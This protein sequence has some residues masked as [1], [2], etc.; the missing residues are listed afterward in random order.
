MKRFILTSVAAV[1]FAGLGVA[2]NADA[3]PYHGRSIHGSPHVHVTSRALVVHGH[4]VNVRVYAR[5]YNSWAYRCWFPSYRTYGYYCG[6]ERLWYYWYAPFNQYL[7]IT[8]MAVYPPTVA[9]APVGIVPV[10]PGLPVAVPT[11]PALPTGA[12]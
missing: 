9:L 11:M 2:T 8:Y 4:S 7:P 1:L 12:T 10:S 6:T 5:G 3:A